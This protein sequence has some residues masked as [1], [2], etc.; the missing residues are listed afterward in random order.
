MTVGTVGVQ[1]QLLM[2]S[3]LPQYV[4]HCTWLGPL[5]PGRG[6]VVE[7]DDRLEQRLCCAAGLAAVHEAVSR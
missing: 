2:V 4:T 6:V 1:F 7:G 3:V 5:T